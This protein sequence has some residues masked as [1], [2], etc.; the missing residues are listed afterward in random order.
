ML[1]RKGPKHERLTKPA[2]HIKG[3]GSVNNVGRIPNT[4]DDVSLSLHEQVYLSLFSADQLLEVL[5]WPTI[6]SDCPAAH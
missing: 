6:W 3:G 1:N 2:L 5:N 4:V